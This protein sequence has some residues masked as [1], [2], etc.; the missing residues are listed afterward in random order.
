M[1]LVLSD[2]NWLILFMCNLFSSNGFIL[3]QLSPSGSTFI[4]SV[5]FEPATDNRSNFNSD[6]AFH[7]FKKQRYGLLQS[8]IMA[9]FQ[10]VSNKKSWDDPLHSESYWVE[11]CKC[12]KKSNF[13]HLCPQRYILWG[14]ARMGRP[15][16]GTKLELWC[17]TRQQDKAS[18]V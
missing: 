2:D 7:T 14:V 13:W 12:L 18:S 9:L 16:Q 11:L 17:C 6:R 15:S 10:S 5:P 8:S 1:S 4:H 3:S